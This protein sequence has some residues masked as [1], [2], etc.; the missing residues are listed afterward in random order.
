MVRSCSR[1]TRT[2]HR[3]SRSPTTSTTAAASSTFHADSTLADSTANGTNSVAIGGAANA[4]ADNSVALGSNSAATRANTV[5]IGTL[6]GERQITNVAAGTQSTDAVNLAQLITLSNDVVKYDTYSNGTPNDQSVTLGTD[7]AHPVQVT[8]VMAARL[9]ATSTDAVNGSQLFATNQNVT[10]LQ[11]FENNVNNGGGIKYFHSNSELADSTAAGANAVAIGGAANASAANSVALGASSVATRANAVSVGSAC[12]ER[13]ITNV[14]AGTQDTDAVNYSQLSQLANTEKVAD[15]FA[16]KYDTNADGT[17]NYNSVTL[18]G[19]GS[20][21]P[22]V[23]T[24]VKA[25]NLSDQHGCRQRF[26]VV[27]HEQASE[28]ARVVREQHQQ[29]RH[30]LLPH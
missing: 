7:S 12:N 25:A 17:P 13:Q 11:S 9:T 26:A 2:S 3:C 21:T 30:H 29:R 24:N 28:L 18:G 15:S 8:N 5:S 14:A 19:T 27:R 10:A 6:N 22:R 23:L 4:S 16:V 1:P 20:T